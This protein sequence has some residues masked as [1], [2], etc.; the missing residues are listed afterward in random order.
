MCNHCTSDPRDA[1]GEA[2]HALRG[3]RALLNE[4]P[5]NTDVRADS[6]APL[7]GLIHQ[8]LD[9]AIARLQDYLPPD[10]A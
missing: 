7:V 6:V 9:P 5:A 8:H 3:L 4:L 1:A 10:L 2:E